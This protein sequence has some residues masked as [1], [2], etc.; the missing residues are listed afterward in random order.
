MAI[1]DAYYRFT[2]IEAGA[3][4]SEGDMNAFSHSTLENPYFW[5]SYRFQ[6]TK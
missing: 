3:F 1:C 4:G 6:R 2:Y 5:M